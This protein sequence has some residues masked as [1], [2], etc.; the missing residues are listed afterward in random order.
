[1]SCPR[2]GAGMAATEAP[3]GDSG[4]VPDAF[5]EELSRLMAE[6]RN[7]DRRIGKIVRKIRDARKSEE[8]KKE[9]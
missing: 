8:C 7:L 3:K 2:R 9:M 4:N 6:K 1:M 5:A